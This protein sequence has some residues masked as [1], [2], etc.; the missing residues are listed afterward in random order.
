M[1]WSLPEPEL[2]HQRG[3]DAQAVPEISA[4]QEAAAEDRWH[5]TWDEDD[6]RA[7]MGPNP[8]PDTEVY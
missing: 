8:H 1:Q 2:W 6:P 3:T 7:D 4:V 5:G